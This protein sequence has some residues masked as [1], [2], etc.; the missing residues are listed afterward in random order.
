[1]T[2]ARVW[3]AARVL[4][5]ADTAAWI[6]IG[7]AVG[8]AVLALATSFVLLVLVFRRG[9]GGAASGPAASGAH[10]AEELGHALEDARA[11]TA[12]SRRLAEIA[13]T[14]D[15]DAVLEKTLSVASS[16]DGVDAAMAVV[17][18][19][20]DTP[21]VATLGMTAEEAAR[22]PVSS[23]PSGGARSVRIGYRYDARDEP[24]DERSG[25]IGGGFAVPLQ[26]DN[27]GTIGTL[28][29]F[30]RGE[31]RM[32]SEREITALEALARTSAPAI[33]TAQ[34][35]REARELADIDALTG[36]HNRR[37]FHETLA[38]EC[39]RAQRYERGLAL[40]VFDVDVLS[41]TNDGGQPA[42]DAVLAGVGERL[43]RAVRGA[44][45]ACRLG[46]DRFAVI[47]PEAGARDA[48]H[49]YRRIEVA[50]GSG[51]SGGAGRLHLSAGIAELRPKDD[52][53][54]LFQRA[55][56]A[57]ELVQEDGNDQA[58]QADGL[59]SGWAD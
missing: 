3:W 41:Q 55:D 34:E 47:L 11:E 54:A 57:L 19:S 22:Q 51:P 38:R 16:S 32:P 21:L 13:S 31:D 2:G 33:R 59:P 49:L 18:H 24:E 20:E 17:R 35:L 46:G 44:D 23:S 15:L 4:P 42:D 39:A 48:E 56:D 14:S 9:R 10:E 29:V 12:R 53:V 43:R 1:V 50:V 25:L 26:D 7:F 52:V 8:A 28:A 58:R 6:V 37:F 45:V 30:W 27:I 36:V 40:L 5:L